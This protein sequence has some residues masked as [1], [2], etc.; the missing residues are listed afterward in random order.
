MP[1]LPR[2][3][4]GFLLGLGSILALFLALFH[5]QLGAPTETSRWCYEI[6]AKKRHLAEAIPGPRLLLVGGSSAL[7]GLSARQIR[8]Q[9]GYPTVNL[10]THAGLGTQYILGLAQTVAKPGDTILL[11]FEYE[12][13]DY[14]AA[15]TVKGWS[16]SLFLDYVFARDP[17]YFRSLPL[18]RQWSFAM[19]LSYDRLKEGLRSRRHPPRRLESAI[20]NVTNLNAFGDQV[21][22]PAANRPKD[23]P[24]Q[25]QCSAPLAH[26]LSAQPQGF[27]DFRLFI[28]WAK[29]NKIRVLAT[30]PSICHRPEYDL[31]PAQRTSRDLQ[32]FFESEGVQVLG[33]A[34]EAMLPPDQ[35]FDTMYHPTDD[36]QQE[37]TR[38]LL[39]H[40]APLLPTSSTHSQALA[41]TH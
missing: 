22:H 37:R 1:S 11:G 20:Y 33:D 39:L 34:Q 18:S 14:P 12:L 30:F 32:R 9:T 41:R 7:F 19:L 25:D 8:E 13:Y 5:R 10:G 40:L 16:D 38:R 21:G 28:Q 3:A 29:Q 27:P 36:G 24:Y 31:A 15:V 35:F 17:H 2:F 23:S 6:N 4:L 26:G